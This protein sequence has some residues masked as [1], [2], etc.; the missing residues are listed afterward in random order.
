MISRAC[1]VPHPGAI[2]EDVSEARLPRSR[3]LQSE[4][5]S[6]AGSLHAVLA[7]PSSNEDAR[8][9]LA[10]LLN[11]LAMLEHALEAPGTDS[12]TANKKKDTPRFSNPRDAILRLRQ[13]IVRLSR[14][15][16]ATMNMW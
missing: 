12:D 4:G 9:L 8:L 13:S 16:D 11:D 3:F 10:T 1:L 7:P 2:A 14:K 15:Q 5:T 6:G